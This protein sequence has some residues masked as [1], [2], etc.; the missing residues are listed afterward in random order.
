MTAHSFRWLSR[1]VVSLP[2]LAVAVHDVRAQ[3]TYPSRALRI[4]LPVAPGGGTD[5]VARLIGQGLNERWGRPVVVENRPGAGTIIASEIVAK[6]KP[7]GYTLL[8]TTSTH[9]MNPLVNKKMPYDTLRDFTPITQALSLPSLLVVHPSVAKSVKELVT[10]AKARPGEILYASAGKG[11]NPHL[12]MELLAHLAQVRMT[13]VPYKSGPPALIDLI[14]GHVAVNVSGI[15][16]SIAHARSGRLRA[17]GVTGTRRSNAAPDIP[18]VDEAGLPGYEAMQWY[19]ML[20]PAGTPRDIIALLH[21]ESVA[22]LR[23]PA[24]VERLAADG[25]DVVASTPE[26]FAAFIK[27]ESAKWAAVAKTAGLQPE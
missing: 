13:H 4:V 14:A 8:V 20:A 27:A 5:Q 15:S 12:A 16:S 22:L 17:L 18:T 24:T 26:A 3:E 11:S 6:S 2:A 25:S 9:I 19:G 7:D 1:C 21:K 10:L 23:G